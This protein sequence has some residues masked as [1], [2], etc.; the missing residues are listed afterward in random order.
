M[1]VRYLRGRCKILR[2]EPI[3]RGYGAVRKIEVTRPKTD[4]GGGGSRNG[5][6]QKVTKITEQTTVKQQPPPLR[7]LLPPYSRYPLS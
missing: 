4:R 2:S 7:K 1:A 3:S 5:H 6:N